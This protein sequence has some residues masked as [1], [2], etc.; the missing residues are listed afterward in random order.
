MFGLSVIRMLTVR[1]LTI[2][3]AHWRPRTPRYGQSKSL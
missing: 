2:S 1:Y 3:N